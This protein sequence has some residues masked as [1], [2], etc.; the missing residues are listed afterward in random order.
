[1]SGQRADALSVSWH[2]LTGEYPPQPG[3]VSDHTWQ[4]SEGLARAGC[5]VH[6]WAPGERQVSPRASAREAC[7]GWSGSWRGSPA[8]S[9]CWCST[10][11]MPLASGP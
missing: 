2:L 3:G 5:A 1:M 10:C 8:P 11:P 7:R 4:V 9:D 6:V